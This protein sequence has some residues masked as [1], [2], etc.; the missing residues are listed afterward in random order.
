MIRYIAL[1]RGINVS[2]QK[3]IKMAD[4]KALMGDSLG[5]EN[6]VTY[7]QSGNVI[8]ETTTK[9]VDTLERQIKKGI[10]DT[11]GFDVPVLVKTK[12][13]LQSVLERSPFQNAEDLAANKIYYVLLQQAPAASSINEME[14]I[15]YQ[16][17][18]FRI[19]EQCVY[20]NCL[21]GA[22][23]AKLNNNLVERKLGVQA[24]TRN[25]R[26]MRKLLELAS[27]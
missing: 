3:K 18:E 27:V 16:T 9:R 26:T 22:G 15:T 1:L 23:K 2:G 10:L 4:L 13:Q 19:T 20:L 12:E 21:M 8:F 7:I 14:K 24:T 17:E 6:V 25:D 5:F 11:F